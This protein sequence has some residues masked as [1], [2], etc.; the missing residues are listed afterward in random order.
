MQGNLILS[1]P[2]PEFV[3]TIEQTIRKVLNEKSVQQDK[4]LTSKEV[5]KLFNISTTTLQK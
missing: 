4:L 2:L 3:A 1:I 5:M